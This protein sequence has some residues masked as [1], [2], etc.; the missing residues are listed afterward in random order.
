M[1]GGRGPQ[2]EGVR[3]ALKSGY[4]CERDARA[5]LDELDASG[6]DLRAFCRR[7]GIGRERVRYWRRRLAVGGDVTEAPSHFERIAQSTTHG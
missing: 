5:V 3:R 7:Y 2:S 1:R 4:W 6:L